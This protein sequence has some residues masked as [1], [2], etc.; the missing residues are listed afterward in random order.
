MAPFMIGVGGAHSKSGK[1]AVVCRLLGALKGWGALK[2]TPTPLYSSVTDDPAILGKGDTDTGRY[3]EAG[4]EDVVWVQSSEADLEETLGIALQGLSHLE[5]I[6]LEGN[7]AI[8]VLKPD[9]VIFNA[10][11]PEKFKRNAERVLMMA[12]LVI[13]EHEVPREVPERARCFRRDDWEGIIG[14]ISGAI[15]ERNC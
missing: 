6:V 12:D 9:I 14:Y 15:D 1:T 4:A 7:S 8:E 13:F 11:N 5:G 2:C 10:G 3:L